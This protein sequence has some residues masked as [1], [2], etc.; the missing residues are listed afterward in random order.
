MDAYFSFKNEDVIDLLLHFV[1]IAPSVRMKLDDSKSV[2]KLLNCLL[3]INSK[4]N[5]NPKAVDLL[6]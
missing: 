4:Y 5:G 3:T 1:K 6:S 2:E